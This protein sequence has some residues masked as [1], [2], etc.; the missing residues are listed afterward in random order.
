MALNILFKHFLE[1]VIYLFLFYFGLGSHYSE[2][3]YSGLLTLK[4]IHKNN[5]Q[6]I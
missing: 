1:C 3:N 6:A 4:I 2:A 5:K